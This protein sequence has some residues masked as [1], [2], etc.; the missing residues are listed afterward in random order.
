MLATHLS[1]LVSLVFHRYGGVD[2]LPSHHLKVGI[3]IHLVHLVNQRYF[4][5]AYILEYVNVNLISL[6]Y[7]RAVNL[8]YPVHHPSVNLFHLV[9]TGHHP[10]GE[11][12][13]IDL[14]L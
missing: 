14:L 12:G 3:H 2:F 10:A 1:V 7:L 13:S 6:F 9:L 5:L 8:V 11:Y 4:D